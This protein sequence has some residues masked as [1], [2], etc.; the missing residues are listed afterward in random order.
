M[1]VCVCVCVCVITWLLS[2]QLCNLSKGD[3]SGG[4]R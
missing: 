3:T 2:Y 1:C 4:G